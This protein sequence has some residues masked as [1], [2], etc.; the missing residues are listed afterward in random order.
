MAISGFPV[1]ARSA[2]IHYG[3]Q[4]LLLKSGDAFWQLEK[5]T[6]PLTGKKMLLI[7]PWH[8]YPTYSLTL[9]LDIS[10]SYKI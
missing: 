10:Y 8:H 3:I 9:K 6:D 4:G 2:T 7:G 5:T 1:V